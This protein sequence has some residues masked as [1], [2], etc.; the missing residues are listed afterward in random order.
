VEFDF[1]RIGKLESK[2]KEVNQKLS[3]ALEVVQEH[4]S[5]LSGKGRTRG[6]L[7]RIE[8]MEKLMEQQASDRD[9]NRKWFLG[10]VAG[11]ILAIFSPLI[12][13][14]VTSDRVSADTRLD[15]IEQSLQQLTNSAKASN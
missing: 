15:K 8:D 2:C 3:H 9:A 1:E 11:L 7:V 6:I 14:A 12:T 10:I 4:E 13:V 5:H